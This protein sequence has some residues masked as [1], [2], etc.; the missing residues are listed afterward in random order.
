MNIYKNHTYTSLHPYIAFLVQNK[1]FT[2]IS[3]R[4]VSGY[5][6]K[7]RDV[8]NVGKGNDHLLV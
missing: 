2:L 5:V 6:G 1:A 7:C 4:E 3:C 8:G